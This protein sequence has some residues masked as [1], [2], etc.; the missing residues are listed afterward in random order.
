MKIVITG[1]S[2]F[3][4]SHTVNAVTDAGH[5]VVGLSR[6][7]PQGAR[8]NRSAVYFDKVDV[9]NPATLNPEAFQDAEIVI[10]LVGIIQE[11]GKQQTFER[12]H[13]DGTRNV[14]NAARAANSVKHFI[15]LSAVGSTKDAPSEYSRTKSS[16]EQLV[17]DSGAPFTI[18]RPSLILGPDGEFVHQ[19]IDLILHGGLPMPIP[20]PVIPVPGTGQTKF[21]PIYIDNLTQCIVNAITFPGAINQMIEVGGATEVPFDTL[22]EGF[23]RKLGV[24]KSLMHVP[25]PLMMSLAPL[26][27]V[28]P[29]APVTQDQLRNL[30]RDSICDITRMKEILEVRP[31]SFEQMLGYVFS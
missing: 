15:Y 2:G 12:I 20:F 3:V 22:L 23:Q 9:G 31:L 1:A 8:K 21:Q 5:F 13:V 6:N 30:S 16:A 27:G 14:L 28:L 11:K 17:R 7:K 26:L 29:N 10:H 24:K 19:M 4:G 18:L 25:M